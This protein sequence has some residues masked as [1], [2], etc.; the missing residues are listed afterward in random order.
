MPSP[1]ANSEPILPSSSDAI[2]APTMPKPSQA[3]SK[4]VSEVDAKYPPDEYGEELADNARVWQVYRDEA[5]KHDRR[6]LEGWHRRLDVLLIFAGIFAGVATA[7]I[8]ESYKQ[9]EPDWDEFATQLLYISLLAQAESRNLTAVALRPFSPQ[10]FSSSMTARWVN[11]IWL[12]SLAVNLAAALLAILAKRWLDAYEDRVFSPIS[13]AKD[14]GRR[15]VLYHDGLKF[16]LLPQTIVA[17][18]L[19]LYV[20]VF[21]FFAGLTL[22]FWALDRGVAYILIVVTGTI[23]GFY[24]CTSML[25]Y[26]DITC[27]FYIPMFKYLHNAL[28]STRR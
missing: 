7:F 12:C 2:Y 18:P 3:R 5:T 26:W 10:D 24:A 1:P 27:P 28:D 9:L 16:W 14:W 13:T 19:A 11:R 25:T 22:F 4:Q 20:S 6:Q 8:I 21:L 15:R 17:L 23:V